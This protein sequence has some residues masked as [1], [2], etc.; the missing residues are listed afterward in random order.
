MIH[1]TLHSFQTRFGFLLSSSPWEA[2]VGGRPHHPGWLQRVL[3]WVVSPE[4]PAMLQFHTWLSSVSASSEP[5]LAP[6]EP[7]TD[8]APTPSIEFKGTETDDVHGFFPCHENSRVCTN[9]MRITFSN[10]DM[11]LET[12][13]G[14]GSKVPSLSLRKLPIGGARQELSWGMRGQHSPGWEPYMGEG[15]S[16]PR[17]L[18]QSQSFFFFLWGLQSVLT[19]GTQSVALN[20][21]SERY[22]MFGWKRR[23][24]RMPFRLSLAT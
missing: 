13:K 18:A 3:S 7:S 19:L 22:W 10:M 5:H 8:C 20:Q 15:Q 16:R 14:A 12:G 1:P 9:M 4:S 6:G 2:W 11:G 17:P 21:T 23:H 24:L